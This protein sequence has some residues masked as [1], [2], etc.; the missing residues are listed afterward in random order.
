MKKTNLRWSLCFLVLMTCMHNGLQAQP[1]NDGQKIKIGGP[2]VTKTMECNGE[3]VFVSGDRHRLTLKGYCFSI[4]VYGRE[5]VIELDS[6]RVIS[7]HG[8][9]NRLRYKTAAGFKTRVGR[10]GSENRVTATE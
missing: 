5:N 2:P 8:N 1:N 7:L 3:E 4:T 6:V 9:K 10:Y